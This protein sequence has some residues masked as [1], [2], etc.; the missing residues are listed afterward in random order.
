MRHIIPISGKDSL[1][2]AILQMN[3]NTSPEYEYIFNDVGSELPE[4]YEWLNRVESVL[5]ITIYRIGKHLIDEIANQGFLPSHQAR[6][7]T[8]ICKVE[9]ME[10]FI[11]KNTEATVYYGLRAD[12]PDRIGYKRK[13]GYQI[14]PKY[15]LRELGIGRAGVWKIIQAKGLIPPTFFWEDIYHRVVQIIGHEAFREDL[16]PW[17]FNQL[18]SWRSRTNCFHC[19]YQ[20]QYEFIG[21]WEHHSSLYWKAIDVEEETGGD[22]YTWREGYTLRA[23]VKRAEE[24]K[25]RRVRDIVAIL[26]KFYQQN[27]FQEQKS[28]IDATSC[29]MYC[30][31]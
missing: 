28:L 18:F 17:E 22:D 3:H 15:P 1:A 24:I 23:L 26:R 25:A 11:G 30:G 8:R 19:F 16:P 29:G 6:F 21:L 27:L 4:T 12:E 14:I 9:P 20:R 5:D 10:E 2:T 31:K 7:C 13:A